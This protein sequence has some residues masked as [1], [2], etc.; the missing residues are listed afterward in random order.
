MNLKENINKSILLLKDFNIISVYLF[1]SAAKN[2][3]KPESD[4]DIAFLS[5]LDVDEYECFMK[6]QEL[7]EIFKRDVDLIDLKKASTVFKAQIIGT[8]SLIYCNDDVKRAYF[9]MR[10]LKEYALLNE[11]RAEIIKNIQKGDKI[12]G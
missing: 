10:A 2:E 5:F 6:A 8:S 4:I 11:E 1:G 3:L 12:Y 7:A 9:E